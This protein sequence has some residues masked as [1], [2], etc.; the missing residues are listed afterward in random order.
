M[1]QHVLSEIADDDR[2]QGTLQS[3]VNASMTP[4]AI[5]VVLHE[6][7]RDVFPIAALGYMLVS[8]QDIRRVACYKV[9]IAAGT[10]A[11]QQ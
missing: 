10:V 2:R 4:R 11:A 8:L 5:G 1:N 7:G 6:T 3:M 9:I